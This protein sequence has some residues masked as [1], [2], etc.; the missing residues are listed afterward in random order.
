MPTSDNGIHFFRES[1]E[2][3]EITLGLVSIIGIGEHCIESYRKMKFYLKKT[4]DCPNDLLAVLNNT[5]G[6]GK[7]G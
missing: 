1:S 4:L 2:N 7:A 6:P 5:E 3:K